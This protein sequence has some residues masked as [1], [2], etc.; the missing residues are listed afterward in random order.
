VKVGPRDRTL[1][2]KTPKDVPWCLPPQGN[3]PTQI[4]FWS[5]HS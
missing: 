1:V 2:R 5:V 4:S 3:P